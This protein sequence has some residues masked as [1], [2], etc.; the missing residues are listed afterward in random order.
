MRWVE[1]QPRKIEIF[2]AS[3]GRTQFGGYGTKSVRA[4]R[5]AFKVSA[6]GNGSSTGLRLYT[7]P[8]SRGKIVEWYLQELDLDYEPVHVDLAKKEHKSPAFLQINPLGKLPALV[9]G[10]FKLYES[11]ALLLYLADKYGGSNTSESRAVAAQ[12][13]LFANSTMGNAI[14]IEAFRDK[15]M[16][17]VMDALNT[18]LAD[19]PYLL[20]STFTVADVAVGGY[21]LYIPLFFPQMELSPWPAVMQYIHKLQERPACR[22]TVAAPLVDSEL[23]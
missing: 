13:T 10:D 19:H 5:T 9:D 17:A 22:N 21:L 7:N 8:K 12:W 2:A 1:T 4:Q 16:P 14:F 20:G 18:Q 3:I 6:T 15:Q 23:I 11:G